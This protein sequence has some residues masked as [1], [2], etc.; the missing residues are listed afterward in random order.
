MCAFV[1]LPVLRGGL[2]S[3]AGGGDANDANCD[4]ND[5]SCS[6]LGFKDLKQ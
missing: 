6:L 3:S 4:A 1:L 2:S 5:A